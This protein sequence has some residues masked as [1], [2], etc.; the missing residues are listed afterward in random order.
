MLISGLALEL[1][2][3]AHRAN[4]GAGR[5]FQGEDA[6]QAGEVEPD[7]GLGQSGGEVGMARPV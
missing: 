4:R 2:G 3:V 7:G 5:R 6:C 1:A